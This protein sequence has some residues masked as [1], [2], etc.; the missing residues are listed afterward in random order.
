MM[1]PLSKKSQPGA[2]QAVAVSAS[3]RFLPPIIGVARRILEGDRRIRKGDYA[4]WRPEL[5]GKSLTGSTVGIIEMGKIG[6]ALARRLRSFDAEVIYA[7]L[8]R[9]DVDEER[10]LWAR[11][12]S[13]EELLAKSDFVVLLVHL[14]EDTL[15]LIDAKAL[16]KMK[17]GACLVN[18]G[19]GSIVDNRQPRRRSPRPTSPLTRPTSSRWRTGRARTCQG[20]YLPSCWSIRARSSPRISARP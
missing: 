9:M 17:P 13:L 19:R 10:T 14:K 16:C 3:T 12:G 15:H 4:G 6:R 11:R 7:D 5:Y 18:V 8:R 20:R 1:R 2:P